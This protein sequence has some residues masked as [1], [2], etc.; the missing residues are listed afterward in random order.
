MR[1]AL[2]KLLFHNGMVSWVARSQRLEEHGGTSR[3]PCLGKTRYYGFQ[4]L[5][6]LNQHSL[7]L[8]TVHYVQAGDTLCNAARSSPSTKSNYRWLLDLKRHW[9]CLLFGIVVLLIQDAMEPVHN[10]AVGAAMRHIDAVRTKEWRRK[11]ACNH[12]ECVETQ[13]ACD[14]TS[15][16]AHRFTIGRWSRAFFAATASIHNSPHCPRTH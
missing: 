6:D 2:Q 1:K 8:V 5:A 15:A 12:Y 14:A 11:K 9:H 7:A 4:A 13:E 3:V 10:Y 16:V